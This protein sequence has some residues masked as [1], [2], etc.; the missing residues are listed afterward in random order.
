MSQTLLQKSNYYIQNSSSLK[1]EDISSLQEIIREHN[2]LYYNEESPV[3]SDKEYDE[4]FKILKNLEEK[5]N[6]S[7]YKSP[8]QKIDVLLSKQFQK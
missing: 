6:I 2:K 4:L 1:K 8:T 7:N 3:I 5:F